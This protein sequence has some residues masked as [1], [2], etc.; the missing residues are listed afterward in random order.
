MDDVSRMTGCDLP[1]SEIELQDDK[2]V[3]IAQAYEEIKQELGHKIPFALR[4]IPLDY[5][6]DEE[7]QTTA[8][9][10]LKYCLR[11]GIPSTFSCLKPFYKQVSGKK[12]A[13][14]RVR[15]V[16]KK[17][18]RIFGEIV[19]GYLEDLE[20]SEELPNPSSSAQENGKVQKK[21]PA[22]KLWA[23]FFLAQHFDAVG[24]LVSWVSGEI[25]VRKNFH[26]PVLNDCDV[27]AFLK[28]HFSDGLRSAL[29]CGN[30]AND[31][32]DSLSWFPFHRNKP[33]ITLTLL[34]SIPRQCST[35][36]W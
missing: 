15:K 24:D 14:E 17:K 4:R 28:R 3:L 36:I 35:F 33:C 23:F 18:V 1:A 32:L 11:K 34:L 29:A 25:R 8:D 22:L 12:P 10:F 13:P 6:R 5:L 31:Y 9:S 30:F 19:L 7:F 20:K 21:A 2:R 16:A 27:K 26:G